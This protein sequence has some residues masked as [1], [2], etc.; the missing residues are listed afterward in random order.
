MYEYLN[1]IA[2]QCN[3]QMVIKM[4]PL[5]LKLDSHYNENEREKWL[6]DVYITLL[7]EYPSCGLQ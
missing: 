2:L 1:A 3:H 6:E 5:L 4:R 7:Y